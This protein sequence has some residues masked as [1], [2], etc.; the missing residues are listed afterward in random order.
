M[1]LFLPPQP[2]LPWTSRY[3]RLPPTPHSLNPEKFHKCSLPSEHSQIPQHPLPNWETPGSIKLGSRQ[4]A[5]RRPPL[6]QAWE[7][8][9]VLLLLPT[10]HDLKDSCIPL[11]VSDP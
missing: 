2:R 5:K 7:A 9:G 1:L 10:V 4:E 11:R 6:Q 3:T 8:R